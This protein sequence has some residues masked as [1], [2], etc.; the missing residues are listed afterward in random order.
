MLMS[1]AACVIQVMCTDKQWQMCGCSGDELLRTSPL[2]DPPLVHSLADFPG[3]DT[4]PC[5]LLRQITG[6]NFI[7]LDS[8]Q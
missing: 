8:N 1:S 2:V 6:Y 4:A 7:N 3:L 5:F